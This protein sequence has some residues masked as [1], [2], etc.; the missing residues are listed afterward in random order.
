MFDFWYELPTLFRA[1]FALALI[2]AAIVIFFATG[3]TRIAVGL[4]SSGFVL[5]LFCSAGNDKNGYNF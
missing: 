5:L 1:L 4:G 3:G 2:G